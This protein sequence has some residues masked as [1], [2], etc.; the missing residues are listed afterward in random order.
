MSIKLYQKLVRHLPAR[1]RYIAA[2]D[3]LAHATTGKYG[4]T[5]VHDLSAMDAIKRFADDHAVETR[6]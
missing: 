4:K 5:V 6:R 1:L 3:V 2:I